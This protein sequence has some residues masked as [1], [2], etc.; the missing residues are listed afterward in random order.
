MPY[1][2][3]L[4]GRPHSNVYE[5]HEYKVRVTLGAA[6]AFT[7]RAKDITVTRPSTTTLKLALPKAY[8]EIT[9][10]DA[11]RFAAAGVAGLEWIVTT[12]SVTDAT[13][14]HI[15]VTSIASN[16][17]ATAPAANDVA[18]LTLSVSCDMLNDRFTG[19]G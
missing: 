18:Y 16:G 14:P 4:A 5:E 9:D 3:M 17:T 12:N 7:Y 2:P 19:S 10:F 15:I 8:A 13:D 11:G 1:E 6:S